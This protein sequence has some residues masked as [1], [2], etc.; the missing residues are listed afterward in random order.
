MGIVVACVHEATCSCDHVEG[1]REARQRARRFYP[2]ER[3]EEKR[4]E[5]EWRGEK[6]RVEE[7]KE[8]SRVEL[9]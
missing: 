7:R 5:A 1:R 8:E 6:S 9:E 4:K 3:K 2:K